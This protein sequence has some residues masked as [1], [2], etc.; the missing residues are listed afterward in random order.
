MTIAIGAMVMT[1][2]EEMA[3]HGIEMVASR[4]PRADEMEAYE[5]VL[6]DAMAGEQTLFARE[7]YIAE[8]WRIVDPALRA[9]TPV[10]DYAPGTWG[11]LHAAQAVA[12]P[13]GWHDPTGE[14]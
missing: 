12:P 9:A 1:P 14:A 10:H 5:R 13:G 7:D 2:G 6:T 4:H 3:G 11:P 8:A